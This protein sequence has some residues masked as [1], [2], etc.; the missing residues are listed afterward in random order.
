MNKAGQA[1]LLAASTL[2]NSEHWWGAFYRRIKSRHGSG[3]ALKATARKLSLIFY[4]MLKYKIEFD[5][6]SIEIYNEY[7]R[8]NRLKYVEKQARTLGLQLVP[9]SFVS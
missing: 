8:K 2:K 9:V 7:F 1:F 3:V 4:K 6:I 5:P